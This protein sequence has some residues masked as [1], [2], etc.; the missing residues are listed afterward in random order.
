M[1][2]RRRISVLLALGILVAS[3]AAPG[4]RADADPAFAQR[5]VST[6]GALEPP[7]AYT[8]SGA[9]FYASWV[10]DDESSQSTKLFRSVDD[11]ITWR[12]VT[13]PLNPIGGD[14]NLYVDQI[15]GRLFYMLYFG[16][17]AHLSWTDDDGETWGYPLELAICEP[18]GVTDYPKLW[19]SRPVDAATTPAGAPFYVHL[20]YNALYRLA[21]QRSIDGGLT[22]AP[23]PNPDPDAAVKY[24]T[25]T[26]WSFHTGWAVSSPTTGVI[27]MARPY[28]SDID[29]AISRDNGLT[30]TRSRIAHFDDWASSAFGEDVRL[31]IDDADNLY[32]LWISHSPYIGDG[33]RP[34]LSVSRDDGAT[35]TEPADVGADGITAAKLP[36]IVAGAAGRIAILYVGSTVNGGWSAPAEVMKDATWNA[37]VGFSLDALAPSPTVQTVMANAA[38]DPLRRGT[39]DSRCSPDPDAC[40]YSCEIGSARAGM[41]DYL[42][43]A[44]NP[45]TGRVA[46]SIVDL[47]PDGCTDGGWGS[48][49]AVVAQTQGPSLLAD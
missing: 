34:M 25:E 47:C 19:T 30:W 35:W 39:C 10:Y 21:C 33:R 4:A 38:D 37:Y 17:C 32:A 44:M 1:T 29:I 2:L 24:W 45:R 14:P 31:A 16:S 12:D 41:F 9:M 13:P 23:A 7:L 3:F 40:I 46:A 18:G 8:K 6:R 5:S 43:L 15:T 48:Q 42:Q 27:Y 20:C 28:C 22:F 26:C 49:A 36:S 11:G